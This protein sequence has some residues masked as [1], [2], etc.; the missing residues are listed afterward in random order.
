M[1]DHYLPQFTWKVDQ[2]WNYVKLKLVRTFLRITRLAYWK[3]YL[4]IIGPNSHEKLTKYEIRSSY[5]LLQFGFI[6]PY[7]APKY[8]VC[9]YLALLTYIYYYLHIHVYVALLTF[10]WSDLPW[11]DQIAIFTIYMYSSI[12]TAPL[13]TILEQSDNYI[14]MEILRFREL[15]DTESVVTNAFYMII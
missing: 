11:F 3:L 13:C 4:A 15:G 5:Y 6:Y 14:F 2:K 9:P 8:H 10:I 7:L 12:E 1:S